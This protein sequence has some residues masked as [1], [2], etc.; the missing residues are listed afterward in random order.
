[1]N[2]IKGMA[3]GSS[4]TRGTFSWDASALFM[5]L[6]I[7]RL[8]QDG[9]PKTAVHIVHEMNIL[10]HLLYSPFVIMFCIIYFCQ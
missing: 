9:T 1:M 2:K 7:E 6:S 4:Y 5:H 8:I 3:I 10:N